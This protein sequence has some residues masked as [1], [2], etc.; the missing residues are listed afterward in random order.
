MTRAPFRIRPPSIP[1]RKGGVYIFGADDGKTD[2][3]GVKPKWQ[4]ETWMS[5]RSGTSTAAATRQAGLFVNQYIKQF[6]VISFPN[7]P[8][9]TPGFTAAKNRDWI[10]GNGI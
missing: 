3:P 8:P 9:A 4:P 1:G 6:Q 7:T 2:G 5:R 10:I